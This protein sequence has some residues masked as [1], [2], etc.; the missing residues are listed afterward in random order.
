M[1]QGN[2]VKKHRFTHFFLLWG[3]TSNGIHAAVN[4]HYKVT[5]WNCFEPSKVK[6]L[7]LDHQ[8]DIQRIHAM[9]IQ[10]EIGFIPGRML[11]S[12]AAA[13]KVPDGVITINGTRIA[14]EVERNVKSKRRYDSIIYNYLKAIKA[15][16]YESVIYVMPDEAKCEQVKNAF[17][18]I[19]KITM[20]IN[21]IKKPLIITPEKHLMFFTFLTLADIPNRLASLK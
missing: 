14:I 13:D 5:D 17:Y 10:K 7:T 8:L 21:G 9:C 1:E 16:E 4:A 6:I 2:L 20:V 3:I 15:G 18:S 12:R 11:G 19:N